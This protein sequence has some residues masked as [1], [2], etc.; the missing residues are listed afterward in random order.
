MNFV[1]AREAQEAVKKIS[2]RQKFRTR[3]LGKKIYM[4][5]E[6][7]DGWNGKLPFYL[8]YCSNC[9]HFA[10]DYPHGFT[11]YQYLNCSYCETR[12]DFVPWWIQFTILW[13]TVKVLW[14]YRNFRR[15]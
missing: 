14:K 11:E 3:F 13:R 6:Q 2:W 10:K 7:R 5:D 4:G 12:Y 9:E 8:F 15:A 1:F